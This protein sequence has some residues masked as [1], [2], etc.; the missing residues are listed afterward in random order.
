MINASELSQIPLRQGN[1]EACLLSSYGAAL[2]PITHTPEIKYFVDCCDL[3]KINYLPEGDCVVLLQPQLVDIRI[4][5]TTRGSGYDWL[6]ELHHNCKGNSFLKALASTEMYRGLELNEVESK[7]KDTRSTAIFA[8]SFENSPRAPHSICVIYDLKLGF[9][10]R[11]S[12]CP[13]S[14]PSQL[15]DAFGNSVEDLVNNLFGREVGPKTGESI[16][17]SQVNN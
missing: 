8:I 15:I 17:F 5:T 14:Q 4:G 2:Y 3:L 1:S 6:A 9:V 10:V 7:L 11:D 13:L 12:S 16:L